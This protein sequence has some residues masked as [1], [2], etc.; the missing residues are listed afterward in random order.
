MGKQTQKTIKRKL[1][2]SSISVAA[3]FLAMLGGVSAWMN[4]SSTLDSLEYTMTETV[5]VA[6]ESISHDLE[7]YQVLAAELASNPVFLSQDASGEEVKAECDR[8]IK[9]HGI[10]DVDISD[11]DGRSRTGDFSLADQEYFKSVKET[12]EIYISDPLMREDNG[13]MNVVISAP[14]MR[15]GTFSGVVY[16]GLDAQFLCDLVANINIGETGNASL[17]SGSG[18]TIGYEDVQLVLDVYNTQ[19]EAQNDSSL[20]QLAAVERKVMEGQT[21]FD[22]YS[23][24]GVTKFAAYAPVEGTRGWGLYVAVAKSEF[25]KSTYVGIIVVILISIAAIGC[26]VVIMTK[27]ATSIVVPIQLCVERMKSLAKGDLHSEIPVITT[28]DETQQLAEC[29]AAL[30]ADLQ[31]VIGDIDYCLTEMSD[32][33]FAVSSKAEESY[34]GDFR[35]ILDSIRKVNITL[36][37]TLKEITAV[38]DQVNTGA[39][40]MAESAQELAEGATD[41]AGAVEELTATIMHVAGMAEDSAKSAGTAYENADRASKEAEGSTDDIEKLTSAMGRISDTSREIEKIIE[42]IEEIASQ[43]NLLSLNASIE[44]ARAGEAGRGFAVVADQ[45]GKLAD[46][47]ARSA[48]TTR[49]LIGKSLEEISL[50]NEITIKTAESLKEVIGGMQQFAGIASKVSDSSNAQAE[51]MREIERGIEQISGVVQSN[52]AAAEESSATSEEL[53]AQAENLSTLVGRFRLR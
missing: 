51:T 8:I 49:E 38:A 14:M 50:G 52:S 26:F 33:N 11:A 16:L 19:Q 37:K 41:Q 22:S 42:A 30:A 24:G 31:E 1:L 15:D 36:D 35:N 3:I 47:S 20:N 28:G 43:T 40:Q 10:E 13:L 21:G 9:T 48:V 53:S 18:N 23:Y 45:I 46:E 44:A 5:E 2:G 29:A 39:G 12:G 25:M 32:G 6:A 17:I 34:V 27:S 4:Y 7:T